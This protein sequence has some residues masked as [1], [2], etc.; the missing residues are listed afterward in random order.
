M[1]RGW[2]T[3][4]LFFLIIAVPFMLSACAFRQNAVSESSV[5]NAPTES[6]AATTWSQQND[7]M[8]T[9]RLGSSSYA[10][11][12]ARE[13]TPVPIPNE[14]WED[15]MVACYSNSLTFLDFSV[16][17]FSMEGYPDTLEEFLEQEAEE[18]DASEIV[19]DE[20]VNGIPVG[21]YRSV[22]NYGGVYRDGMT[23]VFQTDDEYIELDFW[24][25][26]VQAE[27]DTKKI[28]DSLMILEN[29]ILPV[30]AYQIRLSEDWTLLSGADDNPAVYR[31]G[32][33][34]LYLYVNRFPAN[35]ATLT[36][37][38]RGQGGS[39]IETDE[40]INGIP[41]AFYR[42]VQAFDK[43]FHSAL[44]CV[45]EDGGD[46]TT[47]TFRLDGITAE[48]EAETILATLSKRP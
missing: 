6:P 20:T 10:V 24:F 38:A 21:R 1:K 42:S 17:Q 46:F 3:L 37:F 2:R 32:N 9:I 25:I 33:A 45:L 27:Q 36:D 48:E 15:D 31:S 29:K 26:G 41:V 34:S 5:E 4:S 43:T 8:K 14:D 7:A 39:D 11:R 16:Y 47:L 13:F 22:D 18:Y 40:E 30:G 28:M 44:T 23:Y 19:T 12:V 35:G